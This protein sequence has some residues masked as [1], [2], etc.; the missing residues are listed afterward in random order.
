MVGCYLTIEA[1]DEFSNEGPLFV[2]GPYET[3]TRQYD[4]VGSYFAN[5][6]E[7]K[8]VS[9]DDFIQGNGSWKKC[10]G[11]LVLSTL[12]GKYVVKKS[13]RNYWTPEMASFLKDRSIKT[14]SPF[15]FQH[16]GMGFGT[17]T[18]YILSY[19]SVAGSDK[20]ERLY[21][22]ITEN[23]TAE[24]LASGGTFAIPSEYLESTGGIVE[25]LEKGIEDGTWKGIDN[26]DVIDFLEF[27]QNSKFADSFEL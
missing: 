18:K 16:G 22:A 14:I 17:K 13:C 27:V 15:R 24:Y 2:L 19:D 12:K 8:K 26:Y 3:I 4:P 7:R 5:G 25:W 10:R 1:S 11:K 9:M 23:G 6:L 20:G 21:V